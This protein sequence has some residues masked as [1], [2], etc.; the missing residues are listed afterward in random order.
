MYCHALSVFSQVIQSK[1]G[2]FFIYKYIYL[3]IFNNEGERDTEEAQQKPFMSMKENFD[4]MF[5]EHI[6]FLVKFSK[7]TRGQM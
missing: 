1:Q 3:Y 7:D 6:L 2:S 4:L 5:L